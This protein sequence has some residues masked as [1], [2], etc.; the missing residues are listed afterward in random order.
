M[1]KR[2][3]CLRPNVRM[4]KKCDISDFDRGMIVGAR[5]GGLSI[6]ETADLWD[7]QA[8]QFAENGAKT[9]NIQ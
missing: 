9:K 5:H 4:G 1:A 2:F 8:Q 3:S 7:F 6:S